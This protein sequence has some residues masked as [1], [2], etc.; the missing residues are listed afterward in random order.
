MSFPCN[1]CLQAGHNQCLNKYFLLKP[2][3]RQANTQTCLKSY[4]RAIIRNNVISGWELVHF[5]Q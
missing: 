2:L 5:T 4:F 3:H 1:G